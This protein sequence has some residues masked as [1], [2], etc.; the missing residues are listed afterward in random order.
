M[1]HFYIVLKKNFNHINRN[2]Y[3]LLFNKNLFRTSYCEFHNIRHYVII[4]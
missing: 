2:L 1:Q 4:F 3:N